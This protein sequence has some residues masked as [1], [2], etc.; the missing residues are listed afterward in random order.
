MQL[1]IKL[2][3][4]FNRETGTY[5]TVATCNGK[6]ISEAINTTD[7]DA[8]ASALEAIEILRENVEA[9]EEAHLST[10]EEMEDE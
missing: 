9:Q 5:K 4:K 6:N 10:F 3:T 1:Q 7:E 8:F 2:I